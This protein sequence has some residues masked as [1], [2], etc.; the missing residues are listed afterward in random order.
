MLITPEQLQEIRQIVA[1]H[2]EALIADVLG[3]EAVTPEQLRRLVDQGLIT[4]EGDQPVDLAVD[5][6]VLGQLLA[7]A[8][9]KRA[10]NWSVEQLHAH[11]RK[12]PL[13]LTETEL[14][15][16]RM[17]RERAGQYLRGLGNR[18]QTDVQAVLVE[19][20]AHLRERLRS[21][22][23]SAT[24]QAIARRETARELRSELGWRTGD[25]TRDWDRIARTE[26]QAALREGQADALRRRYGPDVL[27][28]R[29][30]MP[31][32]CAHCREL[33]LGPDGQ[34]RIF[35]LSVLTRNGTNVGRKVAEW[36]ST[37]GPVHPHCHPAGTQVTTMRGQV[38]IQNVHPGDLVL[39]HDGQW[40]SVTHTWESEYRG[41]LISLEGKG[42]AVRA[43]P[44]HPL[45][46]PGGSWVPA[47]IFQEGSNLIGLVLQESVRAF[48]RSVDTNAENLPAFGMKGLR[49]ARVLFLFSRAGVPV[50]AIDLNGEFFIREGEINQEL[51][52]G[53]ANNRGQTRRA[54]SSVDSALVGRARFVRLSPDIPQH[55]VLRLLATAD[56]AVKCGDSL[57]TFVRALPAEADGLRL[58][59]R[60][61]RCPPEAQVDADGLPGDPCSPAYL[62]YREQQVEVQVDQDG[63]ALFAPVA[64]RVDEVLH[65]PILF[66]SLRIVNVRRIPF[67]GRVFNLTVAGSNS[68]LANGVVSHNC[69]CQTVR[70][71]AGW[72]FDEDGELVPG[73]KL[74]ARYQSAADLEA[75]L[76]AE[77]DLR[78][79]RRREG[80]MTYQGI[81]L[82]VENPVGST[83][84][85]TDESGEQGETLMRDAYGFIR[86][87][88]GAGADGEEVDVFVGPDPRAPRAFVVEQQDPH[89]GRWDEQKVMLGYA[90]QDL[91][92]A[93]YRAHYDVPDLFLL[94]ATPMELDHLQRWLAQPP[95]EA[96]GGQA[97]KLMVPRLRKATVEEYA[98]T[99][100]GLRAPS[101]AGSG[102]NFL[103]G[104]I[105]ALPELDV[106]TLEELIDRNGP[107]L[108]PSG[109]KPVLAPP[110]RYLPPEEPTPL[111]ARPAAELLDQEREIVHLEDQLDSQDVQDRRAGLER[112][113]ARQAG[114]TMNLAHPEDE[115]E[116]EGRP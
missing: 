14:Q 98:H 42:W 59:T 25:W 96:V 39:S 35:P 111:A 69:R 82:E 10:A 85:W 15:A 47:K 110:D 71:P 19:A 62:M 28:A 67:V 113:I 104:M 56:G 83:R 37:V 26:Q 112:E 84:Y 7:L 73:G 87:T 2:H 114:E 74:G 30:P 64:V 103:E 46:A 72:G 109:Q 4:E 108:R 3:R 21:E 44:E 107:L 6:Y 80:P 11:L 23:R 17:A 54:E 63:N 8:E 36:R 66:D 12:N 81:P 78:K 90:T 70:V 68:Y 75:G 89:T 97:V 27:V 55:E 65:G 32:A 86:R 95:P 100:A 60:S 48:V 88:A 16:M 38:E 77:Q 101:P 31:D 76:A 24:A 5:P 45:Q 102:P 92:E 34:P 1:D 49:L 99:R 94:Y 105:P 50:T 91:A 61:W 57:P 53:K 40:H 51:I 41:D 43:T 52:E 18:V 9:Q 93:A 58:A 116:G 79:G 13:P 29:I 33:H 106:Y 20:D 22:V 115:T